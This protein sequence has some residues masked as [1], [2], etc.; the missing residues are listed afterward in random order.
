MRQVSRRTF[1]A[2]SGAGITVGFL[3]ACSAIK[4][5]PVIPSRPMPS[6]DDAQ[7]WIR[8]ERGQYSLYIPRAEMGQHIG[9]A[10]AAIACEA[11]GIA[12][13]QLTILP[14]NTQNIAL[15]KATVGS[16]SIKDFAQPL[17]AACITLKTKVP[18][19]TQ[20]SNALPTGAKTPT[21]MQRLL[22]GG[23]LF[24][25][26]IRLPNMLYGRVL[27][28]PVS[29]EFGSKPI[30][31]DLNKARAEKGFV[32]LVVDDLL[33]QSGSMG[34]GII[35]RTPGALDRVEASLNV[36]WHIDHGSAITNQTQL[37]QLLDV[38]TA[39]KKGNLRHVNKKTQF[40]PDAAWAVDLNITVPMAAHAFI[41]PRCA[42][43]S[44]ETVSTATT[45]TRL[46]LWVG[47]QDPFYQRDVM[48]KRLGLA[49]GAVTVHAQRI[50]GGFGGKTICTVELEA[51]VLSR[52]CGLPIKVQW[53][54]A[55]EFLQAFHRPPSSHRIR[56]GLNEGK[57]NA[58]WHAFNSSHILFTS[59]ALP[60]WIQAVTDFIGDD[61][62]ARGSQMLYDVSEQRIEFNALRLPVHTG[63][64]RG[65]G[66]APNALALESAIDEAAWVSK[67]D[68]YLF[69][70][71]HLN[72]AANSRVRGVL[73]AVAEQSSWPTRSK[74]NIKNNQQTDIRSG[75]G[76]ACGSYKGMSYAAVVAL[77]QVN[78]KGEVRVTDLWCAH[79][80]GQ[81]IAPDGVKAQVE[82]NLV[83]CLGMVL[84]ESLSYNEYRVEQSNFVQSPIPLI[85][86]VPRMHVHLIDSKLAST[87]AG[88]TAMIAGAAAIAN[89]VKAATGKRVVN[90][91]VAPEFLTV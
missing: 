10:L 25:G 54:R 18:Q 82:G 23:A 62:V 43:A 90:F 29:P 65:L 51:A 66:A 41:E 13:S 61:G 49:K 6:D 3:P 26:D 16:D 87:G 34:L 35:A 11:L 19:Q 5:F 1:L 21:V 22:T 63:P 69:R 24:A 72:S 73:M 42:V 91:P 74:Q 31:Y 47:S 71:A 57:I 70:L 56:V 89:A 81:V 4:Q 45:S 14:F 58:W 86:Q 78:A 50:G 55:Q 52:A 80:C 75:L 83:W 37:E 64:W 84:T 9:D 8:Y 17:K 20:T 48:V 7:G 33:K 28:A 46:A 44:F 77:V 30:A 27:R 88:E 67:Q 53:S 12:V 68:P 85:G 39:L 60:P 59:A 76:I 38:N 2:A 32:Q 36:Q 40:A 15:V 79:D